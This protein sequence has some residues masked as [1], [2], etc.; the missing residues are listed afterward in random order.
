M[1]G[2]DGELDMA[3]GGGEVRCVL[4]VAM[5]SRPQRLLK[6]KMGAERC[7][8]SDYIARRRRDRWKGEIEPWIRHR[9]ERKG[10]SGG[11]LRKKTT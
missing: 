8:G 3:D 11:G 4:S 7:G 5:L 2:G 1:D 9:Q 6:G 10:R